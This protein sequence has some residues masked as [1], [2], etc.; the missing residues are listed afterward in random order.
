M[1]HQKVIDRIRSGAFSRSALAQMRVNA[2]NALKRGDADARVVI[3]EIDK[4]TPTDKSIVFMGFCPGAD[5]S[6]RLDIEWKARGVCTF[7]FLESEQ[8]SERFNNI[9]PGDLIV[10]K[11]REKFGKTMLL[12]GH[13]RVT[14]VKY[15]QNGNRYLEM[16]WSSQDQVIE[17]PLMACNATVD[18]RTLKQVEDEMPDEFFAWLGKD[19]R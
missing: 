6:N 7:V 5:F 1:K 9:W 16:N 13:G 10:L 18:V 11:K 19:L 17:V 3:D 4:T 2:E 14:G 15:D 8:Q 12:Y